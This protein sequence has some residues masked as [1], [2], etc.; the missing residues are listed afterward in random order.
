M[1]GL[2]LVPMCFKISSCFKVCMMVDEIVGLGVLDD[3]GVTGDFEGGGGEGAEGVVDG[4]NLSYALFVLL[5]SRSL[6]RSDN[7]SFMFIISYNSVSVCFSF[8]RTK[9]N[10]IVRVTEATTKVG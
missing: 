1:G 9:H 8:V 5:S 6:L 10:S 3:G 2:K 7:T 4:A